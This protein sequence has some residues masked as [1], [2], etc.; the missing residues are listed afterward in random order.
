MTPVRSRHNRQSGMPVDHTERDRRNCEEVHRG[1]RFAMIAKESQPSLRRFG[2]SRRSLHPTRDGSLREIEPGH[3]QFPMDARCTPGRILAHHAK[4]QL[5][6]LLGSWPSPNRPSHL[7]NQLPIQPKTCT[8]PADDR[9]WRDHDECLFPIWPESTYSNPEDFIE[10][11]EVRPR[12]ATFQNDE[13]LAKDEI[14][15]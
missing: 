13:L 11:L 15:A 8:V 12:T 10:E 5:P 1:N 9:L 2:N 14:L 4:D 7:R 3:E 6:N